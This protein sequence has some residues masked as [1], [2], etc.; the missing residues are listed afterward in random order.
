MEFQNT[1][2]THKSSTSLIDNQT[3]MNKIT[4]TIRLILNKYFAIVDQ[5][6]P[7]IEAVT[8]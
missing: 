2:K 6:C 8:S 5:I 3:T 7:K 4:R 1:L